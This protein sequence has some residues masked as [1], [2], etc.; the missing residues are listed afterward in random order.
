MTC[1]DIMVLGH[2]ESILKY[3]LAHAIIKTMEN[4][5]DANTA[6]INAVNGKFLSDVE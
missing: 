4:G 3:C 1:L 5:L 6:T 2:G